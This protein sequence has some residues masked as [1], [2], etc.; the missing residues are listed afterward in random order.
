MITAVLLTKNEE[1][2]IQRSLTS[3]LWC[4]EVVL[5][6]DFSIDATIPLA[7]RIAQGKL[8][9]YQRRLGLDY[10]AQR[11]FALSHARGDW[12]IFVDPD[13]EVTMP[14]RQEIS[15]ILDSPDP[16]KGYFIQR[17]DVFLGREL[18]YGETG[19]SRLLRL[20]RKRAGHWQRP[21]HE[22]WLIKGKTGKLVNPLYHYPHPSLGEFLTNINFFTEMDALELP[23][24]GKK[25]SL[26]RVFLNPLGKF[27]QNY[28]FRLGFLDGFAGLVMAFMMSLHSL[29]VRV[30]MYEVSK[31]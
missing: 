22:V 21:V 11:N 28:I 25:F 6:D 10:S 7:R 13:E 4:D 8:K 26:D 1:E 9:V 18:R 30:K 19:R 27:L 31:K 15:R 5:V 2:N 29:I 20:A 23:R 12:V 24:E 3:L 14:L 17:R 16:L